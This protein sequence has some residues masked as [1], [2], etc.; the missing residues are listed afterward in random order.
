MKNKFVAVVMVSM[1]LA[2][3][4]FA[5]TGTLERTGSVASGDA[6]ITR[7]DPSL[8]QQVLPV[9]VVALGVALA[10][11]YYHHH[12]G[13]ALVGGGGLVPADSVDSLFDR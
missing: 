12:Y 13:D 7:I 1:T 9:L 4:A 2:A 10:S 5:Q 11:E 6:A 8:Q 3:S